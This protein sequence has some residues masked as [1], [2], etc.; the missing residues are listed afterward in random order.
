MPNPWDASRA[1]ASPS[2]ALFD[3]TKLG[4]LP[5]H[6]QLFRCVNEAVRAY[7]TQDHMDATHDYEHIQR[8]VMLAHRLYHSTNPE[9][10]P[11]KLQIDKLLMY[12]GAMM[13]DI[14]DRKYLRPGETTESVLENMIIECCLPVTLGK[15]LLYLIPRVSFNREQNAKEDILAACDAFPELRIIQDAD[16]LDSIGALGQARNSM[17]AAFCA[18]RTQSLNTSVQSHWYRG[19]PVVDNMKTIAG[20][21]EA[22]KRWEWME[23]YQKLW[24]EESNVYSVVEEVPEHNPS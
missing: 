4:I 15:H 21:S 1:S 10:E 18:R 3:V 22:K 24:N 7:M 14:G 13:H 8:V 20:S 5:E 6:Q 2:T 17:Y 16:R 9:I 19:K 12:L 11:W 23:Q